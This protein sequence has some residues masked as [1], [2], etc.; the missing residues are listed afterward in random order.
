MKIYRKKLDEVGVLTYDEVNK[1][2][3]TTPVGEIFQINGNP[4]TREPDGTYTFYSPEIQKRMKLLRNEVLVLGYGRP[5]GMQSTTEE[6]LN[7][8]FEPIKE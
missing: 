5:N 6:L 4:L 1:L 3:L 7:N 2:Y 8:Q